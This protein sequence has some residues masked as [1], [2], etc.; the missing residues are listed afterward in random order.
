MSEKRT[1][2]TDTGAVGTVYKGRGVAVPAWTF[3]IEWPEG[4]GAE[5]PW[6]GG[7]YD[8]IENADADCRYYLSTL[9]AIQPRQPLRAERAKYGS[10]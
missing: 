7:Y 4:L 6:F 5:S 3:K 9:G 10:D 8:G 1:Y 2:R